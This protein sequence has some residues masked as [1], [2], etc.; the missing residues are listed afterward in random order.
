MLAELRCPMELALRI[1]NKRR[2]TSSICAAS[3]GEA[4]CISD[5]KG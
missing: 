4:S 2:L 5:R 1:L 3:L